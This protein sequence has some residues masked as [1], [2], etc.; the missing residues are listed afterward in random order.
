MSSVVKTSPGRVMMVS[1]GLAALW[2]SS[3]GG[4]V[5]SD[6]GFVGPYA[7]AISGL[8]GW[9]DAGTYS[10]LVDATGVPLSSWNNAVAGITDKS[11]LGRTLTAYHYAGTGT[12]PQATPRLNGELG[13]VGLNT[14]IP[15]TL[16]ASGYLLP[17]MD[18]DTGLSLASGAVGANSAWTVYMVWSRPNWAQG[19]GAPASIALLTSGTTV[20]LAADAQRGSNARLILFPGTAQQTVLTTSL[21]R[22]HTHSIIIRNSVPSGVSVWLDGVQ[23]GSTQANPLP[24]T[25]S[26]PLLFLHSGTSNGSAQCWF[27]EAAMWGHALSDSDIMTLLSCARRWTRGVRKGLQILVMGQSNAG[28]SV[29]EDGG[30]LVCAQGIAWHLGALAY[31]VIGNWGSSGTATC[32]SGHGISNMPFSASDAVAA[33]TGGDYPGSFLEDPGDGSSPSDWVLGQDGQGVQYVLSNTAADDLADLAL[34]VWPWTETDSIRNYSAKPAY[35]QAQLRLLSLLRSGLSRSPSTLP[36]MLWNA[37]P[38]GLGSTG[39]MQLTREAASDP[40][41]ASGQNAFIGLPQTSDSNP[42]NGS[43]DPTTGIFSNPTG[44]ADYDHRDPVDNVR[45]GRLASPVAARA[46]LA[47]TGGDTETSIPAAVPIVGGPRITHV[48]Q[49]IAHSTSLILTITHD[50]GNDLVVALQATTGTGFAVMDG[51]SVASPGNMIAAIQCTYIDSMHLQL[52][53]ASAPSNAQSGL[54]LFYPYGIENIFRGNA[55]TDNFAS[56]TKP[57]GWDI[58]ADLGSA[59]ALNYPLAATTAPIAVSAMP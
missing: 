17:Q 41:A 34:I 32:I 29:A 44:Q 33:A 42:R 43:W 26:G 56:L 8:T 46:I 52:T 51:G 23:I 27:H 16:P 12:G 21:E 54:L 11:G 40:A 31:N 4:A 48:Y 15:P 53:L 55:V 5:L 35:E 38:F 50:A 14:V 57:S 30:W 7:N 39:G 22:R 49:A 58:S 3:G 19:Y 13:G 45:F 9:W 28:Y 20:I 10:G 18:M 25:V 1:P 59:W 36:L 37:I 2:R 47:S 24:V 6:S